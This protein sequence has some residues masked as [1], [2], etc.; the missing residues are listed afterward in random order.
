MQ[1]NIQK[2]MSQKYIQKHWH[3]QKPWRLVKTWRM[4][5][6]CRMLKTWRTPNLRLMV[7]TWRLV[8]TWWMVKTWRLVKT[9]RMV[10]TWRIQVLGGCQKLG[11]WR[12]IGAAGKVGGPA[13]ELSYCLGSA[14]SATADFSPVPLMSTFSSLSMLNL[15]HV[16]SKW[17]MVL[18][19]PAFMGGPSS[20][21]VPAAGTGPP[22]SKWSNLWRRPNTWPP[23]EISLISTKP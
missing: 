23:P 8:K 15:V 14:E 13:E 4:V 12:N 1:N 16:V 7:K 19:C 5:K 17:G 18:Q 20:L 21:N 2:Y 3:L 10:K 9:W 22:C 6:T 11:P